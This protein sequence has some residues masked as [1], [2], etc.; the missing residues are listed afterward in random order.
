MTGNMS[1][2]NMILE[3]PA[4]PKMY[5]YRHPDRETLLRCNRCEKPICPKCSIKTPTGYRCPDCVRTQQKVFDTAITT[6]YILAVIICGVL[7][8]LGS[9]LAAYLGFLT[10]FLAPAAGIGIAEV[11]RWAVHRRRSRLLSRVATVSASL[12]SLPLLIIQALTL[13]LLLA[14]GQGLNA[15]A[16]LPLVWQGVYTSLVASSIYYRLGGTKIRT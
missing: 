7:S 16:I 1:Q 12:A 6:D 11:V 13:I 15:M 4:S 14:G 10:I 5:C 8:F 2:P 3:N 9:L